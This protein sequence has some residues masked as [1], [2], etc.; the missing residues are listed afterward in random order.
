MPELSRFFGISIR[1]YF[2]DHEP[3]HFHVVYNEWRAQVSAAE[4]RILEGQLPPRVLGLVLEWAMAHRG[5][6][7]ANWAS[8]RS[9]GTFQKIDPLE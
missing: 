7:L 8:L 2:N 3:A 1:M 4:L 9:S 6:L 5:E